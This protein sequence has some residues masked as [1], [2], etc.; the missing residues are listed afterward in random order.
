MTSPAARQRHILI[1][2][3]SMVLALSTLML[4]VFDAAHARALALKHV[5]LRQ[6]RA[7][8]N[9]PKPDVHVTQIC[10]PKMQRAGKMAVTNAFVRHAF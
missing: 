10:T 9:E 8:R 2:V 3:F 5:G 1:W 6:T 4:I 7:Y